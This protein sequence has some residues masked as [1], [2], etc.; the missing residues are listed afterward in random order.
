MTIVELENSK[1]RQLADEY[2]AKDYEVTVRPSA[3][4][5][6]AFLSGF[7]PDLVATSLTDN[8]VVEVKSAPDLTS[9]SLVGLADIVNTQP[10]WRLELVVVN[11][12]AAQEVPVHGELVR[13]E[14]IATLLARAIVLSSRTEYDA[15]LMLAWSAAEAVLR[16]LAQT[17]GV[18]G[19]RKSSAYVLKQLY[20]LGEID[21]EQYESFA[22]AMEF[23]N[24]FAHGFNASVDPNIVS[25]LVREVELLRSRAAA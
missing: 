25:R 14:Q 23:R 24:A 2:L 5:L 22:Q 3:D 11:P 7:Q 15:A 20:T 8:V 12:P 9:E 18:E 10:G 19:E 4:R 21:E 16:R 6:P 17:S 1:L 13:D